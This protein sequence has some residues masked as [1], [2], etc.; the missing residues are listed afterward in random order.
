M[1]NLQQENGALVNRIAL[2]ENNSTDIQEND[3][4]LDQLKSKHLLKLILQ[5]TLYLN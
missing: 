1:L 5:V 3:H 4:L 2:L